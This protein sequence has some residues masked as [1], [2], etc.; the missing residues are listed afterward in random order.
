[1]KELFKH[2]E[3]LVAMGLDIPLAVKIANDLRAR[4][5]AV[6]D[7]VVTVKD[8]LKEIERLY[9]AKHNTNIKIEDSHTLGLKA[10]EEVFE[11]E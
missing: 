6:S 1:M 10:K 9:N 3:E 7:E 2:Q 11:D 8:L 5:V 4:G